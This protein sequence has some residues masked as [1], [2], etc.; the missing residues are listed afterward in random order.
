[1]FLTAA[2]RWT[3]LHPRLL[4]VPELSHAIAES[5]VSALHLL[6]AAVAMR[7]CNRPK[8][9]QS[10]YLLNCHI[11]YVPFIACMYIFTETT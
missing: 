8:V 6:D 9:N 2:Y 1:M 11:C 4:G 5:W 7:T 10:A 3:E